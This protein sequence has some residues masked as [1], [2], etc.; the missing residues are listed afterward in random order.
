M[1]N[2]SGN[3]VTENEGWFRRNLRRLLTGFSF[4]LFGI[5]SLDLAFIVLPVIILFSANSEI[6]RKRIQHA[7]SWH[8][9]VFLKLI[10]SLKLMTLKL[11]GLEHLKNDHGTIIIANHP[12]LIDVVIM[13]AF[14]PEVDCVVKDGL[15]RNFFLRNI[16]RAAGYITNSDSQALLTGCDNSLKTGRNLIIFP[17]GTRTVPGKPF[18]FQ[19]GVSHVALHAG[20]NIRP[21]YL[22][23]EPGT[24]SKNQKWYDIPDR[25]FVFSLRV[26]ELIHTPHWQ[27]EKPTGVRT[28]QLTRHLEQHYIQEL[29][30][31]S[32]KS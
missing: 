6:R 7:I 23:C 17:E 2:S 29:S 21:V 22:H 15:S 13:M 20:Y 10:Q 28:R 14:M 11:E 16:V 32:W 8:F 31:A 18:K 24:L 25:P 4:I 5:G 3:R 30:G 19:R 1:Q 12:T 27:E 26:G 9:L